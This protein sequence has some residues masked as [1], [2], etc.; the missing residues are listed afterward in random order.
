M[1]SIRCTDTTRT[2]DGSTLSTCDHTYTIQRSLY[3]RRDIGTNLLLAV[4]QPGDTLVVI[5]ELSLLQHHCKTTNP[6]RE[7]SLLQM[8]C[9]VE[10]IVPLLDCLKDADHLY[11]VMPFRRDG[12]LFSL[13]QHSPLPE[14]LARNYLRQMVDILLQLKMKCHIGHHDVSLENFLLV[15]ERLEL[16]DFGI[17][18]QEDDDHSHMF[19]G[20]PTYVAPELVHH[21]KHADIYASDVWS[22]G[23]CFYSMLTALPLYE[24][25]TD[26]VFSI[27]EKGHIK[28]LLRD[29]P[30]LS[31]EAKTLLCRM[32]DPNP[33]LR[34]SLEEVLS[35]IEHLPEKETWWS[36]CKKWFWMCLH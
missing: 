31:P 32:L 17:C 24:N 13:V 22:L 8:A 25:P 27:L 3:A 16:I 23:V 9:N 33:S 6:Y 14:W 1:G 10:G 21:R 36:Q 2:A 15:G 11:L 5:K 30:C 12:D 34:P 28:T 19:Y 18:V 26:A 35:L 29:N 20:K 4:Q 7:A